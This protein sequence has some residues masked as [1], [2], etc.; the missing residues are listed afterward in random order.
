MEK[1]TRVYDNLFEAKCCPNVGKSYVI[2]HT[3]QR[4]YA[5][6]DIT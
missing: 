1:L 4:N 2:R 3:K 6:L 5:V